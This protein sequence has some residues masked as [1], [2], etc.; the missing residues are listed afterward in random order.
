MVTVNL[1]DLVK[2][3]KKGGAEKSVPPVLS[4]RP[5]TLIMDDIVKQ[6]NA[7]KPVSIADILKQAKESTSQ[8]TKQTQQK[9]IFY[10]YSIKPD[11]G[12]PFA[13]GGRIKFKGNYFETTNREL[14]D[15]LL[16]HYP[17][18]ISEITEEQKEEQTSIGEGEL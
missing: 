14:V 17:N 16:K 18:T 1:Q 3:V 13:P 4:E 9:G 12:A 5:K 10:L 11:I 15:H 2:Q 6:E 8:Q 7:S